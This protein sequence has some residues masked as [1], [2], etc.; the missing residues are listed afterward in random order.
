MFFTSQ[1]SNLSSCSK[2]VA[3]LLPAKSSRPGSSGVAFLLTHCNLFG[4]FSDAIIRTDSPSH[5]RPR[6]PV[7]FRLTQRSIFGV[8]CITVTITNSS[9]SHVLQ[10]S[11]LDLAWPCTS[12]IFSGSRWGR[13]RAPGKPPR[14]QQLVAEEATRTMS[15]RGAAGHAPPRLMT[16]PR[17]TT[18]ASTTAAASPPPSPPPLLPPPLKHALTLGRGGVGVGGRAGGWADADG[19]RGIWNRLFVSLTSPKPIRGTE[20]K[21][22]GVEPP[23]GRLKCRSSA[24]LPPGAACASPGVCLC[25]CVPRGRLTAC[26]PRNTPGAWGLGA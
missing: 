21:N 13:C 23:A 11:V 16:P 5:R 12:P 6:S 22:L 24:R 2:L 8:L 9:S 1:N 3:T 19:D 18:T 25:V 14:P 10:L 15:Q 26:L 17:G 7:V 20:G 4:G